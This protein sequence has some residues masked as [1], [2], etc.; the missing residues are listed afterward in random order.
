MSNGTFDDF[1]GALLAFESGW[2]R[3]RYDNGIIADWQLN[4]WAGGPVQSFFPQYNSW[5]DL[6]GAEWEVMA[7]RSMNSLGFV[8]F[9]FGE[10][11][12]IDLGYYDATTFYGNG[13][14]TNTWN[15]SWTGK[16]G[17]TSL[18]A[19]MTKE[20]QDQA[21]QD[22]FGYNLQV[23][24]NGLAGQGQS[25]SDLIGTTGTYVQNGVTVTVQLTLTGIMAAAHLRGA[26]GTLALLQGG[27]VS[28][29]EYGTSILQYVE[30]FG[31]YDAPTTAQMIAAWEAGRTGDE[32]LG[33]PTIPPGN[34][35]SPN[36]T[37]SDG[38]GSGGASNLGAPA[39]APAPAPV[40]APITGNGGLGTAGVTATSADV[41][42]NWAW[43]TATVITDFD[44]ATSTIFVS[45][46]GADHIVVSETSAG[47]V[48]A[49]PSNNQT[50][51]LAGVTLASLSAANFTFLDQSAADEVLALVGAGISAPGDG[52]EPGNGGGAPMNG[53][54]MNGAPMNG[55]PMN[56]DGMDGNDPMH[57]GP[58][59]GDQGDHMA[60]GMAQMVMI[61]LASPSRTI[62]DFDPGTDMVHL[63]VGVSAS[64]LTIFEE[65]GDALGLTTRIVV[66][67]DAGT[68]L[69]TTI[70]TGVRLSDLTLANFSV[71]EQS[72]LNEVAATIGAS[73]VNP[74]TG[75]GFT[76]TYDTDGSAP[77]A[78]T[79][80]AAAG[81]VRYKV[82][83]NAD[84]IVGFDPARDEL[85]FGSISVHG[86]IVTKTLAGEIALD[87]PWS[88]AV[89]VV[90]GVR[91]QDIGIESFGVVG[92]EHL[93]QD[94]G[95]VLSWELG[96]G[97]RD[98]DTVY[99]RSHEYGVSTVIDNFDVTTDKIS[100]LYFGTRERLSVEDTP[101]G[102][103]I[104]SLPSGQSF[105]FSNLTTADLSPDLLE[106]HFDQVMEDNL[107][108]PFGFDQNDVT[109]VDRTS[110]LTPAAPDGQSTDGFQTREG[111]R[112]LANQAGPPDRSSVTPSA[113][114]TTPNDNLSSSTD[115]PQ[116]VLINWAW[117][118]QDV[119]VGFDPSEDR[120]N[121]G[122]VG[123]S[124]FT[125]SEASDGDLIIEVLNNGGRSFRFDGLSGSDLGPDALTAADWNSGAI[126]AALDDLA[127]LS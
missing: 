94:L 60:H 121:F 36:D 117:G 114:V 97:P 48:I 34:N 15:G 11:L 30:Q 75:N 54:P 69:S 91:F 74:G 49:V 33:G 22:A 112:P 44:P 53:A 42:I 3:A 120:I 127:M 20:V 21:I 52:G 29:D 2:D 111:G 62:T 105:T 38:D 71:A 46:I 16:N 124:Q 40:P 80:Q 57:S 58:M 18:E 31:G 39:P 85:D 24:E 28:A 92:N 59:H 99:I 89:Q 35:T 66:S 116:I 4:Q 88:E 115:A 119:I 87:S 126:G 25:L 125:I 102:L 122:N 82:D 8:G 64:R 6:S 96:I 93:R 26:W 107:E 86:L 67:N 76:V 100:F 118:K 79:G 43:G 63:E 72:A 1:L 50:T 27:A 56:G 81:G 12:L 23:I 106:F 98:P 101:D 84:D 68:V 70:L 5:R 19:F 103:V 65:S 95:G 14:A 41:V 110:L 77:P 9:Q 10:A 7:Y 123:A 37:P 109:L 108:V 90:Q 55:A 73:I 83:A 47:V 51:T 13:A 17:A 78:V 104:S 113:S 61:G 45:W 32:G